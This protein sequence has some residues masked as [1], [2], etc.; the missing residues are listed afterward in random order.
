[1]YTLRK[2]TRKDHDTIK[3]LIQKVGINPLGIHWKRFVVLEVDDVIIGCVQRKDFMFVAQELSSLAILPAWQKKGLSSQLIQACIEGASKELFLVCDAK[4]E[5]V[6]RKHGFVRH[7][8]KELS[9]FYRIH[10]R[11]SRMF[12][13]I[14]SDGT[15]PILMIHHS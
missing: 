1:M 3:N 10:L 7:T 12:W 13:R 14:I 11:I 15:Y 5:S 9:P 4:L 6:Y 8:P 2:A